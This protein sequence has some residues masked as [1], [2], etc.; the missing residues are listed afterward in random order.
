MNEIWEVTINGEVVQ[1]SVSSE[2][3]DRFL[4]DY[5]GAALVTRGGSN[6]VVSPDSN[7][8]SFQGGFNNN[9]IGGDVNNVVL[10]GTGKVRQDKKELSWF[11]K[12]W[13]GSKFNQASSTGESMDLWMEQSNVSMETV[14]AFVD[15]EYENAANYVESERM[16]TFTKKYEEGGSSWSSFFGAVTDDLTILP[17]L[18]VSSLGTQ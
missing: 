17:E 7:N 10:P 9:L 4:Q 15:A 6:T 2:D 1:R 12:S 16:K 3:R 14:R 5:P 18:F 8:Y 13:F 11:D